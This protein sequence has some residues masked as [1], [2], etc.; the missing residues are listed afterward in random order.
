MFRSMNFPCLGLALVFVASG[1]LLAD[2]TTQ[3]VWGG[4]TSSTAAA[5]PA[6]VNLPV[7]QPSFT[8]FDDNGA[9]V[10][11]AT[12]AEYKSAS[13]G[14]GGVALRNRSTGALGISGVITPVKAAYLYWAVITNGA[15]TSTATSVTL[16]REFPTPTASAVI[17]GKVVGSGAQPCWTGT[18]ITVYRGSV[19]T[20][21]ATG[22]GSYRVTLKAG[23]GGSTSGGDPWVGTQTLPLWEGASLVIV[24]T[25]TGTVILYDSGISGATFHTSLS[26]TLNFGLAATGKLTLFDSIGADGQIGSSRKALAGYGKESMTLNGKAVSGPSSLYNDSDWNGSSGSPLPQLW[27]DTGHDITNTTPAGTTSLAVLISEPAAASNDCV[28]PVANIVQVE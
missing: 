6:H 11:D 10:A 8:E 15:P 26:Y 14:S 20:T 18:T 13:Y 1:V 3:P 21:L 4:S 17:T 24:G 2:D 23:A 28:T 5:V 19:P 12:V 27:D 9:P 16:E 22:N 7:I 25:G